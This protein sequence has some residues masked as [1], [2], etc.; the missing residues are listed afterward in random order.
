MAKFY[1]W[2]GIAK[3]LLK[4]DKY[5]AAIRYFGKKMIKDWW[6]DPENRAHVEW[7]KAELFTERNQIGHRSSKT[8]G[9][10]EILLQDS[11]GRPL[12]RILTER[13]V[14]VVPVAEAP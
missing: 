10:P 11:V 12:E 2:R 14:T 3:K 13:G 1:S 8:V 4:G 6:K 7:L 5:Y 9:L